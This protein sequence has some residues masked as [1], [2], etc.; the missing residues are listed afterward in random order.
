M[1]AGAVLLPREGGGG[2]WRRQQQQ[3]LLT[4]Q[5][6]PAGGGG[7]GGAG[8]PAVEEKNC[9]GASV[10][11]CCQVKSLLAF[12]ECPAGLTQQSSEGRRDGKTTSSVVQLCLP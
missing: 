1:A 11:H 5:Q 9:S 12:H 7:W 4:A 3:L 8:G 2:G 10:C 6:P